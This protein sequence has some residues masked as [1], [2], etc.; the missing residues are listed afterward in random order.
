[1]NRLVFTLLFLIAAWSPIQRARADVRTITVTVTC[2]NAAGQPLEGFV[3][4][5]KSLTRVTAAV[6][7]T[8]GIATGQ[9]EVGMETNLLLC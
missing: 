5:I 8:S 7:N 6:A 1:M 4:G 9:A 3:V 2:Q